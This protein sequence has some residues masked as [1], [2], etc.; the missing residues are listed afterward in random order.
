MVEGLADIRASADELEALG[1]EEGLAEV[2]FLLGMH[3]SWTDTDSTEELER[4]AEIAH[5]VGNLRLEAACIGWLCID[6]F[7]YD[8]SVEEG[9]AISAR[10][11]DRPGVGGETHRLL[12]VA[13]NLKRMAGREEEGQ[14]DIDEGTSRLRELGR[15]VDANAFTMATACVS[16]LAG[17]SADAEEVIMP[18]H[19]AL[20]AYGE[21]GY[22]STVSGV[23]A[24]ALAGQGRYDEAEPFADE[25]RE[26]GAE[27]DISTQVYW[28]AAKARVLAGRGD[29]DA[30]RVLAEECLSFLDPRRVLDRV[31]VLVDLAELHGAAGRDDEARRLIEQALVLREQKGIILGDDWLRDLLASVS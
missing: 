28:R 6:A 25:A 19:T 31:I 7:W 23:A 17:R 12:V 16:L 3:L 4:A 13:G 11:L 9:L 21:V 15:L 18:A 20:K 10:L 2:L 26:I 5:K 29:P 24:I 1:D 30:A 8:A 14:A 27:D 22:L